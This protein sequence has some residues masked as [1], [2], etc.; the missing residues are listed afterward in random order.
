MKRP[1]LFT[2][3][4]L[5][6]TTAMMMVACSAYVKPPKGAPTMAQVNSAGT[7][8]QTHFDKAIAGNANQVNTQ[9]LP[10][11]DQRA[12]DLGHGALVSTLNS[13]FPTLPNPQ[14]LMYLFG[15]YA[16]NDQL[17]VPGH[18]TVFPMYDHTY[19]ALPSEVARPYNDGQFIR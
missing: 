18:F 5:I 14:N 2:K 12:Q 7:A 8:G 15:H 4:A 9:G 11:V 19:Y 10:P 6:S 16:G 3:T 17:P 13:Q 1:T